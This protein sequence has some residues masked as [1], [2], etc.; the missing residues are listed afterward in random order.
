M[1]TRWEAWFADDN[2]EKDK[3]IL[4]APPSQSAERAAQAF[5]AGGKRRI[6][7]LACGIGRDTF[8]LACRGLEVI[9]ADASFNGIRVARERTT[10][11]DAFPG[12]V[13]ADAR[14][15]PFRNGSFEGVYCFG[16]LHEFTGE[17]READVA[18][19]MA[20]IRRTLC[21]RG[22]L[23]LTAMAG[24][25]EAGLPAVQMFTRQ[26]FEG[27]AQGLR[28]LE[29]DQFDDIGCT[30]REDYPVWYGRFEK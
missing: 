25:P 6:L 10:G 18:A 23:V 21:T 2:L 14:Q 4:A 8:H 20:E 7:D 29:M 27:A 12:L 11:G 17:G 13:T 19:V 22:L 9:G 3:R 28:Q 30:G 26:M 15:L 1:I 5:L 24:E 16:L